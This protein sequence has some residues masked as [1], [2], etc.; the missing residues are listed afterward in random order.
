MLKELIQNTNENFDWNNLESLLNSQFRP[1]SMN[2]LSFVYL[3]QYDV[4]IKNDKRG[5]D[6]LGAFN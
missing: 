4:I 1:R 2:R 5:T 6:F 3:G